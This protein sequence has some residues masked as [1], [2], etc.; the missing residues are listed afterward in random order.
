M[1]STFHKTQLGIM[2]DSAVEKKCLTGNTISDPT[3][4]WLWAPKLPARKI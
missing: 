3:L 2:A 1:I 4:Q